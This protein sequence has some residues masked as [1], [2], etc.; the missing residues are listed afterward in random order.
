MQNGPT[1]VRI[2]SPRAGN[3]SGASKVYVPKIGLSDGMVKVMYKKYNPW[4]ILEIQ[5]QLFS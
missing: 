2:K 5:I 1:K 4:S 3:N